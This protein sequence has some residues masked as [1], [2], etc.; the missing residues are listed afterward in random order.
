MALCSRRLASSGVARA[1]RGFPYGESLLYVAND[2]HTALL[3]VY[4]R[5]FYQDH[6]KLGFARSILVVHN[7][8]HQGRNHLMTRG[9]WVCRIITLGRFS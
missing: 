2:W 6:F 9:A 4:L 7:I 3:P 5:A 8:A 1:L